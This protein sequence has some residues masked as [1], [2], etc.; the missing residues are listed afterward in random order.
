VKNLIPDLLAG[1]KQLPSFPAV[2]VT[3]G[4]NIMTAVAFHFYSFTPPMVMVGIMPEKYSHEL[5]QREMEFG[6]NIPRADQLELVRFCGKVSGR[7]S[8]KYVEARV[9]PRQGAVIGGYLIEECPLNLECVV[10]HQV[11]YPGTHRWFIGEVKAVHM[12]EDYRRE[13]CLMYW[14]KEFRKVGELLL[15]V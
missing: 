1:L 6:I 3:V 4:D 9:T 8:K 11:D 15:K 12:D 5:L 2:L 13:Q 10:V 7:N 14:N